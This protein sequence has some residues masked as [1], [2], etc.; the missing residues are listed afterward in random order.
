MFIIENCI[1][2]YLF[3]VSKNFLKAWWAPWIEREWWKMEISWQSTPSG[4]EG[5]RIILCGES[6]QLTWNYHKRRSQSYHLLV[7]SN[8]PWIFATPMKTGRVMAK[9]R[10][11][12][13][14]TKWSEATWQ[15]FCGRNRHC[16]HESTPN[17]EANR[18]RCAFQAISM[19]FAM[20]LN[21]KSSRKSACRDSREILGLELYIPTSLLGNQSNDPSWRSNARR[22]HS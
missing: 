22:I 10:L 13:A 20:L 15:Q 9:R 6:K 3:Q 21:L 18:T 17:E 5:A 8:F 1:Q 16:H 11:T 12:V 14:K 19:D 2:T 4:L 7:P